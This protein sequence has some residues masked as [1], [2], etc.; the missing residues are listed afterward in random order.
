MGRVSRQAWTAFPSSASIRRL[1]LALGVV[2]KA[3]SEEGGLGYNHIDPD[4]AQSYNVPG[5]VA[6]DRQPREAAW[7]RLAPGA[8]RGTR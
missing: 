8:E 5:F 7:L 1:D 4:V 3:E 6:K 2:R